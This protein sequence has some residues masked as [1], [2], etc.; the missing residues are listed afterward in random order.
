[1][2]RS[3]HFRFLVFFS[4]RSKWSQKTKIQGK[5]ISPFFSSNLWIYRSKWW[6][7]NK[8]Q[9]LTKMTFQD[10]ASYDIS[11]V[12]SKKCIFGF[13]FLVPSGGRKQKSK[14]ERS[15]H[16]LPAF[17]AAENRCR[18]SARSTWQKME[19]PLHFFS[20]DFFSYQVGGRKQKS[21][22][23]WP[24]HFWFL[25]SATTWTGIKNIFF[26]IEIA[27]EISLPIYL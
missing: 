24:L 2:E 3:L 27:T 12:H 26:K 15:L 14:M 22:M 21:K 13:C 1:M 18:F 4:C 9:K 23:E 8:N 5:R 11:Y 7:E 6:E 10:R 20:S 16:F 25:F 17:L 19:W